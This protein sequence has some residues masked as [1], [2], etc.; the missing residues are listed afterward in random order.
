MSGT[1]TSVDYSRP[2]GFQDVDAESHSMISTC[3][4]SSSLGLK[5]LERFRTQ[6]RRSRGKG[7]DRS[8]DRGFE[9]NYVRVRGKGKR[10]V[11][12][13]PVIVMQL[14]EYNVEMALGP[15][16]TTISRELE[17]RYVSRWSSDEKN[18][19]RRR[20]RTGE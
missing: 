18:A 20:Y 6:R 1:R 4:K 14:V 11:P 10:M 15:L 5:E 3:A 17:R 2:R 7:E 19:S 16:E 9:E 13:V 12:E 8:R